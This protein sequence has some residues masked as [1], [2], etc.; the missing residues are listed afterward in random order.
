[1][2]YSHARYQPGGACNAR[3]GHLPLFDCAAS[4]ITTSVDPTQ[5]KPALEIQHKIKGA[6]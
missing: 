6:F 4:Q 2:T 5:I 3:V 1:M